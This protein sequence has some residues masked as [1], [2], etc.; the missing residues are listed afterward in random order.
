MTKVTINRRY[1]P[2]QREVV[3]HPARFKVLAAGRRWGKTRLG[4]TEC[5]R[6]G[7]DGGRAWWIAP[8]YAMAMEGWRPLERIAEDIPGADIRRSDHSVRLPG[9]GLIEVRSAEHP[10]R[11]RGAGLDFLVVDEAAYV[12]AEAWDQALRPAL[13]DRKGKALFIS[14]PKGLDSWFWDLFNTERDGW[15]SFTYPTIAN[16]NID[17]AEVEAAR[18]ELGTLVFSQE[19]RAEFVSLGGTLFKSDWLQYGQSVV[20]DGLVWLDLTSKT[21]EGDLT[22]ERV[23]YRDCQRFC[24]VDLAASVRESAD[25]T[26]IA[27][28]AVYKG[29]LI[30]LEIVRRKVEGPDI[31]P[32]IRNAVERHDLGVAHIEKAGFQLALIQEA[33]RD[34]LPVKEL[35]P[36]RDKVARALPL[37]ARMEAG[38]VWFIEGPWIADLERE[39]LGFPAV[40]HDDQVDA[41]AY[42]ARVMTESR[43]RKPIEWPEDALAAPSPWAGL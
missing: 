33:R 42:A 11:L 29:K 17:P 8:T 35:R 15:A 37:Q 26:V 36:D 2:A 6:V 20:K 23:D 1:H 43:Q 38:D 21:P 7:L 10:Q 19:Y 14:T 32:L 5:L 22:T 25:F 9:G 28:C 27:S 18:A 24:T 12:K 13:S 31:V 16:P 40:A 3:D 39:L 34:G 41:L 30:V 4:V